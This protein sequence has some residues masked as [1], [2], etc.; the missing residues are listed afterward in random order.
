MVE[1]MA[2]KS[3]LGALLMMCEGLLATC[4]LILAKFL[5][6]LEMPFFRLNIV[7]C[8]CVAIFAISSLVVTQEEM[9][10]PRSR[11]WILFRGASGCSSFF[12]TILAVQIGTPLG[13]VASLTSVNTVVAAFLG[14][15]FLGELLRLLH[16][17][18]LCCS[19]VGAFLISKPGMLFAGGANVQLLGSMFAVGSGFFAACTFIASR[20]APETPVH[21]FTISISVQ[22]ALY[23]SV[24]VS[25]DVMKDFSLDAAMASPLR[26]VGVLGAMLV[27]TLGSMSAN[28]G[29]SRWCPA[30]VSATISTAMRMVC[31]YLAQIIFF[32]VMPDALTIGGAALM[33]IGVAIMAFARKPREGTGGV[34]GELRSSTSTEAGDEDDKESLASFISAEFVQLE[35]H[36]DGKPVR[37]RRP[38]QALTSSPSAKVIGEGI[39]IAVANA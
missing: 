39:R 8:C 33:I 29:G 28:A 3:T 23:A 36:L 17:V 37:Q 30:A 1:S 2:S 10:A 31:G 25:C 27:L 11:K 15:V 5:Q 6:S 14:R 7:C 9:P 4:Q 20:K 18:A 35:P 26:A 19:A 34:P 16:V 38:V 21:F 12:L 22:S 24:L 13:D 32:G